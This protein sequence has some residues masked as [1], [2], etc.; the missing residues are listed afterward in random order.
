MAG[1]WAVAYSSLLTAGGDGNR[2]GG[3]LAVRQRHGARKDEE[4]TVHGVPALVP[5]VAADGG[6]PADVRSGVSETAA[7]TTCSPA[8]MA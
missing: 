6:D 3:A 7:P 1:R 5:A 4:A 2:G 8:T